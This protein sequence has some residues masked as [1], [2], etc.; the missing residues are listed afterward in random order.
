M[1]VEKDA[2]VRAV[3]EQIRQRLNQ[4]DDSL[5]NKVQ[6]NENKGIFDEVNEAVEAAYIAQRKL[7]ALG[8]ENRGKIIEAIRNIGLANVELLA[9]MEV[10]ETG[11]GRYEHKVEK[12]HLAIE[13]TPG[14]ED[15]QP[16]V[17]TGDNGITLV[18]LLPYGVVGC[19][20]PSTAPSETVFHNAICAISAGNSAVI[21]PHPA[22]IKTT[23]KVVELLNQAITE[24]G[25]PP[26]LVVSL[27]N[28]T[29]QKAGEIMR[30]P[31]IS[32]LVA[33]G[34]EGVIKA[35]LSSG[36]KSICAGPGNPPVLVDE[37]ADIAQAGRDIVN[38]AGF[39]N[40][41]N[42][43]GEKEVLVIE[44]VADQLIAEMVKHGAYLLTNKQEIDKLTKLVT[45]D[46][47]AINKDFIGKNASVILKAMGINV[48][49]DV[50]VII[51]E[52]PADHITVMKEFLMPILPIIR[53]KSLDEGIELAVC[54]EGG[55][56]HT[57]CMHSKNVDNMTRFARAIS[58]TIFVKNGPSYSGVGNGGEGF[59]A[60]TIAGPTGEGLT[61]P[62]TFART[63]RCVLVDGFNLRS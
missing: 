32:L 35:V 48:T 37:T 18:E 13:K 41:I 2:I 42:C 47:G 21:S 63:Q 54:I 24:C 50:K 44:E 17:F 58:T 12:H 14:I 49:D 10:E 45:T 3:A 22:A 55:N 7:I 61:S 62:R 46:E 38:G 56:R 19:I 23:T 51:Y 29:L 39:E 26:N 15:V 57:A 16:H 8:L 6:K 20:T 36:K 25:G 27:R 4:D 40:D 53:I 60:M 9:R 30:H 33:T 1:I 28:A 59:T 5:M 52:V 11:M 31:K 43:I 34:G